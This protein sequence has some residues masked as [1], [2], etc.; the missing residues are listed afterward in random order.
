MLDDQPQQHEMTLNKTYPSGAEEW[1]CPTCGRRILL[2]V[3]PTDGMT[4]IEP[5][6]RHVSH[7][8]STGGLRI[9][10]VQVAQRDAEP[11][12]ISEESL[13]PWIKAFEDLDLNW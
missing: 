3:P 4:I 2:R 10:A 13:G 8:G 12:E 6:D 11:D 5:G 1:Y 7:S 9:G